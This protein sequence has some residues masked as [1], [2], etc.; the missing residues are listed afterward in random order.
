MEKRKEMVGRHELSQ[1]G[2]AGLWATSGR[3]SEALQLLAGSHGRVGV[4][5]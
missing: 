5:L 4:G 2:A 1:S 3:V